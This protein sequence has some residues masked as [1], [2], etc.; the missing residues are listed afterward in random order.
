MKHKMIDWKV[1]ADSYYDKSMSLA[2]LLLL[3]SF[4]VFPKFEVKPYEAKQKTIIAEDIPVDVPEDI[5]PPETNVQPTVKMAVVMDDDF[6]DDGD[7][8]EEIDTIEG[9]SIDMSE[10][11]EVERILGETGK[12]VDFEEPPEPIRK[13]NP[14]YPDF[15]R[16]AGIK[17]QVILEVEVFADGSVGA[18]NVLKGITDNLDKA[19]VD[20]VKQWEFKP[21]KA[22]GQP[23]AV[24]V[25]FP[26]TFKF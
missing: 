5:K 17:G 2:I 19:A 1:I 14:K 9:T 22:N 21:A 3:F 8:L 18:I 20:A 16:K 23:V 15:E 26:I 12:F 11:T 4:M 24:W 25:R 13:I 6:G 10:E 7:E